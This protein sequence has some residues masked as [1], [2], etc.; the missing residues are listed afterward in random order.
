MKISTDKNKIDEILNRGVENVYP[1]K[2]FLRDKLLSGEQLTIYLG[3]DPTG[4]S[5]HIGHIIP[6]IKLRALQKLGHKIIFLIGD[7][8]AMIGDP[9]DKMATRTV[10]SREQVLENCSLYKDQAS[11]IIDFEGENPALIKHNSQWLSKMSFADTL[12]LASKVTF[13]QM[14]KRDM[15][16]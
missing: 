3:V 10:L 9:T 8:T 16:Q 6:L 5:L 2:D 13:A 14:I 12:E 15:F 1:S 4:P 7:F 11:H